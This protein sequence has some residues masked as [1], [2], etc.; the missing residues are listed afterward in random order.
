MSQCGSTQVLWAEQGRFCN[1][2]LCGCERGSKKEPLGNSQKRTGRQFSKASAVL[3]RLRK[4]PDPQFVVGPFVRISPFGVRDVI[5]QPS[6]KRTIRRVAEVAVKRV[7]PELLHACATPAAWHCRTPSSSQSTSHD[8]APGPLSPPKITQSGRRRRFE[9]G[10][11]PRSDPGLDTPA[12]LIYR[13]VGYPWHPACSPRPAN[14]FEDSP[15]QRDRAENC[16]EHAPQSPGPRRLQARTR[17]WS[18]SG[19]G[20][21]GARRPCRRTLAM[22][23]ACRS[24]LTLLSCPISPDYS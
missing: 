5:A 19:A 14:G 12:V 2:I 8:R 21:A 16:K 13:R 1:G 10:H 20:C 4:L 11:P 3:L 24:C 15:D 6:S 18:R 9:D 7:A 22:P 23:S 17:R